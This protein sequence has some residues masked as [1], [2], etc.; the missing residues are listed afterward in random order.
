[1]INDY[2]VI[3]NGFLNYI[4]MIRQSRTAYFIDFLIYIVLIIFAGTYI[5]FGSHTLSNRTFIN[6]LGGIAVWTFIEYLLHRWF[7]HKLKPFSSWHLEH[8]IHPKKYICASTFLSLTL[9]L[10]VIFF[11]LNLFLKFNDALVITFGF[12]L[13][14][15]IYSVIHHS[16]HHLD[17]KRNWYLN[18][19]E[20]NHLKHHCLFSKNFGVTTILWDII[21]D[22][23][24]S[25]NK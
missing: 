7:L 19:L 25:N 4:L 14:Y 5:L 23:Y 8:H 22:T 11:P 17:L 10:L 6:I 2:D 3:K 21:F 13:G 18:T 24:E 9:I 20:I 16:I 1:M 15:F 12:L